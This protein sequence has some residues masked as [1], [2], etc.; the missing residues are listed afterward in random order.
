MLAT[1]Q[2]ILDNLAN[3][4]VSVSTASGLGRAFELLLMSGMASELKSRGYQVELLRSDGV[5]QSAASGTMTFIQRGGAPSGI[6]PAAGGPYGPTSILFR[7][8]GE[9]PTWEIWNGVQ[10]VGRSGGRHEF[11]ISIVPKRLGDALRNSPSGGRP[12]GHGWLSLECKDT[13]TNGSLDEMRAFV[14]RI[15]DTTL[16]HWH[17]SHIG[18]AAPLCK[19]YSMNAANAGFGRANQSFRAANQHIFQGI[20]RRTGFTKGTGL[21]SM[22]YFVRCFDNLSVGSANLADFLAESCD[23]IDSNLPD[24]V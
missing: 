24:A 2:A 23:W 13:E 10:F 14:A 12:F 8:S 5:T 17:A 21:L 4:T 20:A 9:L 1:I 3:A 22:Y 6:Q 11:D 18:A 19:V 15:Y 16:L 7:R